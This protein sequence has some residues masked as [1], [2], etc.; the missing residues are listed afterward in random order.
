VPLL[1]DLLGPERLLMGSDFPH[2]EGLARPTDYVYELKDF[3]KE[4]VRLVM[5]DN[6]LGLASRRP[7]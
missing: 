6:A 1:R 3:S 4:E 5:R 7:S 2:A